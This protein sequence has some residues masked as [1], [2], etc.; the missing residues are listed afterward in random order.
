[1]SMRQPWSM[2]R[3]LYGRSPRWFLPLVFG[4]VVCLGLL[5]RL[6]RRHVEA[7]RRNPR[8]APAGI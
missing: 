5:R 3:A 7:G 2:N 6:A 4:S 1:M 8:A